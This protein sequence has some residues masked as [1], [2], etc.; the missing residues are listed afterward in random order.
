MEA[1][2]GFRSK[3]E[4][5]MSLIYVVGLARSGTWMLFE[6]LRMNPE[7]YVPKGMSHYMN[8][9][10]KGHDG[11]RK[12]IETIRKE[13]TPETDKK[14]WADKANDFYGME[15]V[16][17][18]FPDAKFIFILRFVSGNVTSLA[19]R[20]GGLT[21]YNLIE[22]TLSCL[23]MRRRMF[24]FERKHRDRTMFVSFEEI[25]QNPV[26]RL[27]H[28]FNFIGSPLRDLDIMLGI[29]KVTFGRSNS[30]ERGTGIR[31]EP[32]YEWTT[33]LTK[34]QINL[35][36]R[37]VTLNMRAFLSVLSLD[38][39]FKKKCILIA[40]FLFLKVMS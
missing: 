2:P 15:K 20:S 36:A 31:K 19:K 11:Y 4:D 14:Y 5:R 1:E 39:T 32:A 26:E 22:Q 13:W 29:T 30:S 27:H 9:S 17:K 37:C 12:S 38:T 25:L 6:C 16:A 40:K 21:D 33:V 28:V 23:N 3:G 24:A 34:D 8:A 10:P 7:I 35:I 18:A